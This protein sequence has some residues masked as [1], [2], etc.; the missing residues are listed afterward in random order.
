MHSFLLAK[1]RQVVK[2]IEFG[3]VS[4]VFEFTSFNEDIDKSVRQLNEAAEYCFNQI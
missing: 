3:V 2:D 4:G 1:V